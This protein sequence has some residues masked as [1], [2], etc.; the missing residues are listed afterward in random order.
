MSEGGQMSTASDYLV[1]QSAK[2]MM[3]KLLVRNEK[4]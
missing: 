2:Q 3:S 1:S 4:S